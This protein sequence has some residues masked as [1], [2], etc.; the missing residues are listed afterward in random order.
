MTG[1]SRNCNEVSGGRLRD[2]VDEITLDL[3]YLINH[4]LFLSL[5]AGAI[6]LLLIL[7]KDLP[8]KHVVMAT[9]SSHMTFNVYAHRYQEIFKKYGVD[10][11]LIP[12][13]GSEAN[14]QMLL[15][16]RDPAQIGFVVSGTIDARNATTVSTMGRIY[17][18]PL[19]IFYRKVRK[20]GKPRKIADFAGKNINIEQIGTKTNSLAKTLFTLN[21]VPLDSRISQLDTTSAI[22][23]MDKGNID[24]IMFFSSPGSESLKRLV[25]H[26][27]VELMNVERADTYSFMLDYL[28]KL[29][30]PEGG[31]NM[32]RNI[33]PEPTQVITAPVELIV[34]NNLH[35]ALKMLL[36][37]AA[38]EVH[39]N[40]T[41]FFKRGAFPSFGR[42]LLPED[43][44]AKLYYAHGTP[45]IARYLPFW[46]V[47]PFY[48]AL[49]YM[50]PLVVLLFATMK[51]LA[52]YRLNRGR[53]KI[54]AIYE[55]LK[56][57]EQEAPSCTELDD[58]EAL[59]Q[60][61][62]TIEQDAMQMRLPEELLGEY[63]T[64]LNTLAGFRR[65]LMDSCAGASPA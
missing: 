43:D 13:S 63:F 7:F 57:L 33:P 34:K 52:E 55:R 23:E 22:D 64:L 1:K 59:S 18:A 29:I 15:D 38:S 26:P 19:W 44:E 54:H 17:Y 46:A 47:E 56:R 42:K 32:A 9:G 24:V 60:R 11:V 35:P 49:I 8:P 51:H 36:M 50:L 30:I 16:E 40:E 65:T 21:G 4:P 48:R 53:H 6:G 31:L 58:R 61:L 39:G 37:R 28:D 12:S 10:L 25:D 3:K 20:S 2:I 27:D 14:A 45:T 5:L 41:Y 62:L